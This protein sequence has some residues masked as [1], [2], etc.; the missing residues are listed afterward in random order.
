MPQLL[1]FTYCWQGGPSTLAGCWPGPANQASISHPVAR[2]GGGGGGDGGQD[3]PGERGGLDDRGVGGVWRPLAA[4]GDENKKL[5]PYLP[6]CW[7]PFPRLLRWNRAA[8]LLKQQKQPFISL[9]R[10]SA[11]VCI[12]IRKNSSGGHLTRC[13]RAVSA[14]PQRNFGRADKCCYFIG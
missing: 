3:G 1:N 5:R 7:R 12:V 11:C 4:A 14:N 9:G 6:P 2:P 10:S 8:T 13:V